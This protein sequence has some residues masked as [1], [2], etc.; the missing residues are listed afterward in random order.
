MG[1][2]GPPL[3]YIL[4]RASQPQL[5]FHRSPYCPADKRGHGRRWPTE[6]ERNQPLG[7]HPTRQRPTDPSTPPPSSLKATRCCVFQMPG[8]LS[9]FDP[10]PPPPEAERSDAQSGK[11]CVRGYGGVCPTCRFFLQTLTAAK[12]SCICFLR[13]SLWRL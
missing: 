13:A 11:G 3:S 6:T 5:D 4:K 1:G 8:A 7:H 2:R 9:D 10:V 12:A